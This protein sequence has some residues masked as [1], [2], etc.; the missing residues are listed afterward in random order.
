MAETVRLRRQ[1]PGPAASSA[2]PAEE[3]NATITTTAALR[4]A[5]GSARWL[6]DWRRRGLPEDQHQ[7]LRRHALSK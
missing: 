7:L 5:P 2:P 4:A 6:G 3:T 1:L